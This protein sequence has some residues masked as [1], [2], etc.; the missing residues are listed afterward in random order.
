MNTAESISR[1]TW[2]K[3]AGVVAAATV[4]AACSPDDT[5]PSGSDQTDSRPRPLPIPP[6]LKPT[7]SGTTKV[8]R[9]EAKPGM[10]EIVAGTSTPTWGYN[11]SLLGPTIRVRRGDDIRI[12]VGNALPEMTTVH[13]HGMHLPA[14]MD[15]GPHQPIMPGDTWTAEYTIKQQAATLWYHPH[16][17]GTTSR[18]A[19]RGLSGLLIVDDDQSDQHDLPNRYGIDDVPL[20]VQDKRFTSDHVLDETDREDVGLIGDTAVVNGIS[21]PTFTAT[22]RRVRFR[23]LDGSTMRL[24]NLAFSDRREFTIIG[25]DGGLL[26]RPVTETSV[27]LSPGERVE[28]VVDLQPEETVTLR[29]VGFPDNLEVDD[30][31]APDFGLKDEFDLVTIVGP[32]AAAPVPA[33]LPTGLN[34]TLRTPARPAATAKKRTFDLEW[35]QINNRL[36]DITRVDDTV[37]VDTDEIWT[38]ANKDN[39]IHNFH[40][41]DTQFRVLSLDKTST[42]PLIDGWKDT[43]LLAPGAVATIALRFTDYTSTRWP[44]M[45]HC[46]LMFHE[47]QGMMGQFVVVKPGQ[48]PSPAIGSGLEHEMGPK[49]SNSR[50]AP[51]TSSNHR[52]SG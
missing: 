32:H 16:P 8:F 20:I 50:S 14:N 4:V 35:F 23:I 17:H 46:H 5:T 45:Y 2:L 41:H 31:D 28:I 30:D 3:G 27:Y 34:P 10:S 52:H 18:H 19:Y 33:A 44:Y 26:D 7:A 12:K 40:V 42:T 38:I 22:T 25:S 21:G 49:P 11:G 9:L 24:F 39:W 47:D 6:I 1:R 51:E 43:I 48:K 36:M 29:A 37:D 13:W 15:G